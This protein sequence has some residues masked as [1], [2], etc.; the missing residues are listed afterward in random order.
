M[1]WN[2]LHKS[3]HTPAYLFPGNYLICTLSQ[4]TNNNEKVP[5]TSHLVRKD[6]EGCVLVDPLPSESRCV[7]INTEHTVSLAPCYVL[8][9]RLRKGTY[10]TLVS[11]KYSKIPCD[12]SIQRLVQPG[13]VSCTSAIKVFPWSI[14]QLLVYNIKG[15]GSNLVY[16]Q[17]SWSF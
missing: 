1:R 7:T 11:A 2:V 9:N 3:E 4:I 6:G 13:H 5:P 10:P 16:V 14:R 15:K 8:L 12:T 17:L